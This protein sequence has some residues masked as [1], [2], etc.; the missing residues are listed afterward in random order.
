[1][2]TSNKWWKKYFDCDKSLYYFAGKK[3]KDQTIKE[4]DFINDVLHIKR[5]DN[6][7]D[8]PCGEGRHSIELA[9]KGFVM[10]GVD[11]SLNFIRKG[12][13]KEKKEGVKI[14]WEQRDMRDMTWVRLFD[15]AFSFWG[16]F[17]YFD[18]KGNKKFL[19]AVCRALKLGKKFLLDT[20]TR[21][22][23]FPRLLNERGWKKISDYYVLE[24]RKFDHTTS[25]T[26]T[27]WIFFREGKIIKKHTSMRLYSYKEICDLLE[28]SGFG[29]F[30]AYGNINRDTFNLD[31][32]R[33]YMVAEKKREGSRS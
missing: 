16:S 32:P 6:I 19:D 7:L 24:E 30:Q 15:G 22:T 8:V 4:V 2:K 28:S 11:F 20:H 23:L 26:N 25:R 13:I 31:S 27:E 5:G 9:K 18:D 3:M 21:E 33:L 1:M 14:H 12:R 17:G 10:T 29:N